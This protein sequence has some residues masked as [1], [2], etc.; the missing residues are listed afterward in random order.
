M[1]KWLTQT[2]TRQSGDS[3]S[4]DSNSQSQVS[5]LSALALELESGCYQPDTDSINVLDVPVQVIN[6]KRRRMQPAWFKRYPWL[7]YSRH[8]SAVLCFSCAKATALSLTGLSCKIQQTFITKGFSDWKKAMDKFADHEKCSSHRHAVMQLQQSASTPSID[9]QLSAQRAAD[10]AR[11]RLALLKLI[12]SVRFLARQGLALR[13]HDENEGNLMQLIQLRSEDVS[14]LQ[15]WCART[16]NFMSPESQNEI[17][18]MMSHSVLRVIADRV[19]K[20]SIHFAVVVDGTQDSSGH[21]QESVCIRYVDNQLNVHET[22]VGLFTPPDTSGQTLA[23]VIKDVLLRLMLPVGNLRAQTYDGAAN[24]A[25]PF[26]GCQGIISR[27]NPLALFFH[28]S[29][30]CANLAAE[31]TNESCTLIRDSLQAV[32]ELGVLYKRSGKYKNIFDVATNAYDS[33]V[34]LKPICPTRWLCRT[35][36]VTAV[37]DQYDAVLTSL[38]EMANAA[39]SDTATKAACLLDQL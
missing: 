38:E 10:Q 26:N 7:H 3:E 14:V 1:D 36:S 18:Q 12:S 8:L 6:G 37:L 35:R 27:E 24:M 25:G 15:S 22:F 34:T 20:T 4:P 5:L 39:T 11:A 2:S 32:H 9:V 19:N 13:G 16:T 31:Y 33:P 29:A 30:Q 21:E 23:N 28:C 17:L